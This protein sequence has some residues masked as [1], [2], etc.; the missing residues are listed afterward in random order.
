MAERSTFTRR[1]RC[2]LTEREITAMGRAVANKVRQVIEMKA[3][4]KLANTRFNDDMKELEAEIAGMSTDIKF[5]ATDRDVECFFDH[6]DFEAGTKS[7]VRLDTHG[8]VEE[9]NLTEDDRQ[10]KLI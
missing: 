10:R 7:V 1:L 6:Y 8:T 2:A 3:A 9:V 4:Q 5:E